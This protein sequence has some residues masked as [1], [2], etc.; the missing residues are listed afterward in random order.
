MI[1][2]RAFSKDQAMNVYDVV[3]EELSQPRICWHPSGKFFFANQENTVCVVEL[4]TQKVIWRLRGHTG[5][6][7]DIHYHPSK[8]LLVSASYDRTFKI[9]G[10]T[11]EGQQLN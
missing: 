1:V 3:T 2:F 4:A 8:D 11:A 5:V 9:W 6:V 10:W 7:R